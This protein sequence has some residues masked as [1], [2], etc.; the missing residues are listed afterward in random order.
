[1]FTSVACLAILA[2]GCAH[3]SERA[4]F[5]SKTSAPMYGETTT[6]TTYGDQFYNKYGER[7]PSVP[8]VSS[9]QTS[10]TFNQ[11]TIQTQN[12]PTSAD[13]ALITQ[14][15]TA[16][17]NDTTLVT[18]APSIQVTAQ[19]GTVTLSGNVSNEQQKQTIEHLVKGT[20]GVVTVNNQLQISPSATGQSSQSSIYSTSPKAQ[21]SISDSS[22]G[23]SA[24]TELK[25]TAGDTNR[26]DR[27]Y[28]TK[29]DFS[30]NSSGVSVG[31]SGEASL[32]STNSAQGSFS[33]Q[34][35]ATS[36]DSSS[37]SSTN[38]SSVETSPASPATPSSPADTEKSG[39]DSLSSTNSQSENPNLS[40]TSDSS[41]SSVLSG[42]SSSADTNKQSSFSSSAAVQA[43][44]KDLS[45]TSDSPS[46]RVYSTNE[47]SQAAGSPS[48]TASST[49]SSGSSS[50]A[51]NLTVQ[52]STD[53]DQKLADQV[54]QE[55]KADTSLTGFSS[56]LRISLDNGKAT[57]R[58]SVKTDAEKQKVEKAVEKI[59]GVTSVQNELRVSSGSGQS[60]ST[61]SK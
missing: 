10:S 8:S 36:P 55:L 39:Q 32:G 1:M 34:P 22:S 59:T 3:K 9:P 31:A 2:A 19:G 7:N 29:S 46:S 21:S 38:Q 47:S 4:K 35:S 43:G 24:S 16:I 20:S 6:S 5:E 25:G 15:R 51:F 23:I 56:R 28:S 58:G 27:V 37:A 60:D 18:I 14:V 11:T 26:K 50:G 40:A 44:T 17:N 52:G 45:A 41:K 42:T 54:K 12:E 33:S 61:E 49:T 30:T 13:S 57:L 48:D 53:A